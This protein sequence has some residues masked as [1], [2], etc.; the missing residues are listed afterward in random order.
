M[1][2]DVLQDYDAEEWQKNADTTFGAVTYSGGKECRREDYGVVAFPSDGDL[3]YFV[4][5]RKGEFIQ[6]NICGSYRLKEHMW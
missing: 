4:D 2:I 5:H 6:Y 3:V 1:S